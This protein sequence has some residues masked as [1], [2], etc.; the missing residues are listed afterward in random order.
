[1]P[2]ITRYRR[3]NNGEYR[4]G[5]LTGLTEIDVAERLGFPANRRDDPVNVGRSWGFRVDGM[6]CAVWRYRDAP[7]FATFGPADAMRAVFGEHWTPG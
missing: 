7:Y 2:R 1:M 6:L 4:T 5:T 3:W